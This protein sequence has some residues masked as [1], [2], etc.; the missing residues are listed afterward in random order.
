MKQC[1]PKQ[2]RQMDEE[3]D[4]PVVRV[5][6]DRCRL[7]GEMAIADAIAYARQRGCRLVLI[8]TSWVPP[9]CRMIRAPIA[10]IWAAGVIPPPDSDEGSAGS[11]VPTRP[12]PPSLSGSNALKEPS[13]SA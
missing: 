8:P 5:R 6:D 7:I 11:G 2:R 12:K 3:I 13:E 4:E 9:M 10:E 1:D